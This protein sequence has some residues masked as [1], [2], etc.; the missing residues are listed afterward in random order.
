M[1]P[2]PLKFTLIFSECYLSINRWVWIDLFSASCPDI[3]FDVLRLSLNLI[4]VVAGEIK[5]ILK[6]NLFSSLLLPPQIHT[7]DVQ[8]TAGSCSAPYA[9][10]PAMGRGGRW[11]NLGVTA[12]VTT[13]SVFSWCDTPRVHENRREACSLLSSYT[14]PHTHHIPFWSRRTCAFKTW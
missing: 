11:M 5:F 13:H 6:E 12:E 9:S 2:L 14:H 8:G 1:S 3:F 4:A 10:L 7:G